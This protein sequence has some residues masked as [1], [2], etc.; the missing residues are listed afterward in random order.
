MGFEIYNKLTD[1]VYLINDYNA[2]FKDIIDKFIEL[3]GEPPLGF[4]IIEIYFRPEGNFTEILQNYCSNYR[5]GL[6]I[7]VNGRDYCQISYG[8]AHELCHIYCMHNNLKINVN[9][10]L[11]ESIC[12][13]SSFYFLDYLFC[14]WQNNPPYQNWYSYAI[15]FKEYKNKY[16]NEHLLHRKIC[17]IRKFSS[18][19]KS[20]Y[21]IKSQYNR[22][23]CSSVAFVL[24][25]LFQSG[26]KYWQILRFLTKSVNEVNNDTAEGGFVNSTVNFDKLIDILPNNLK[27]MGKNLRDLFLS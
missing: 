15:H 27:D 25:Q 13:M 7:N 12:I 21:P 19:V 5:I 9:N 18:V 24:L 2:V 6:S 14:K 8:F 16:I 20:E 1:D 11:I 3:I 26:N 10:W 4:R 22:E 17:D 23:E